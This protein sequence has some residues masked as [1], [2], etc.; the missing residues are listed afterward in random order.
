[1]RKSVLG[2]AAV[3]GMITLLLAV[4]T[5]A[6]AGCR[7]TVRDIDMN[8]LAEQLNANIRFSEPLAA[9]EA[10]NAERL[11][12]IDQSDVGEVAAYIGSGAT[13]DE[14][15]IWKTTDDEAAERVK[16]RIQ[17]RIREQKEGYADYKPEEV[18]KLEHAV[19]IQ[20]GSYVILCISEDAEN[21]KKIINDAFKYK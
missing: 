14:F 2:S 6:A 12:R 11:Y 17:A 8:Q 13:V 18:P 19:L 5:L 20:N 9:L 16:E 21:A 1:M 3:C 15:S 10:E 4:I 7:T